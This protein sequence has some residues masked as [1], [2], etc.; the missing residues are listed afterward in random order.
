MK[1]KLNLV[2]LSQN[3]MEQ[4]KGGTSNSAE[5]NEQQASCIWKWCVWSACSGGN[6]RRVGRSNKN[7]TVE[8]TDNEAL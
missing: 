3:E 2:Q 7:C 6:G 5:Q 4:L 1:K 8:L